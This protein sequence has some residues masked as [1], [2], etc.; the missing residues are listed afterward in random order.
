M[1]FIQKICLDLNAPTNTYKHY[2]KIYI[3]EN[4]ILIICGSEQHWTTRGW[5]MRKIKSFF[6]FFLCT[7][8][9]WEKIKAR[10]NQA[11]SLLRC[12]SSASS[13]DTQPQ[14]TLFHPDRNAVTEH[15]KFFTIIFFIYHC[16]TH[17]IACANVLVVCWYIPCARGTSGR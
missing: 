8:C 2:W 10:K 7:V 12:S 15:G 5:S 11:Q 16:C 14:Q 1:S 3:F 4:G 13:D 17:G 9:T 6:F